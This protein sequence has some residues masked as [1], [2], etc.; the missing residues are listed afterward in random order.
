VTFRVNSGEANFQ[1]VS[2]MLKDPSFIERFVESES[3]E[4]NATAQ[5]VDEEVK[6]AAGP[7]V[8]D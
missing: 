8:M 3:N 1:R 4:E 7:V 5:K 6:V 2:A